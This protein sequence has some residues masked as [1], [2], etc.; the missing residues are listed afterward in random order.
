MEQPS[1]IFKPK[2]EKI[3]KSDISGKGI[4]LY[5]RNRKSQ[6]NSLYFKKRNF[7]KFQETELSY[8]FLRFFLYF[9]KEIFRTL[10]YLD[11]EAYSEPESYLEHCQTSTME[12]L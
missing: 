10:A 6:E 1:A 12:R 4:F 11:L 2:L 3:T 9:G 7:L 5:F 8:I